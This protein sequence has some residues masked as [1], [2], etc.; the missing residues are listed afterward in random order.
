MIFFSPFLLCLIDDCLVKCRCA[1]NV[2]WGLTDEFSRLIKARRKEP[3]IPVTRHMLSRMV[4]FE[5]V[6]ERQVQVEDDTVHEVKFGRTTRKT[7]IY[8]YSWRL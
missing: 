7:Q 4:S 6:L 8:H 2:A 1:V 3:E 5:R